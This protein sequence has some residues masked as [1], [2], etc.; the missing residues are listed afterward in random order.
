M[1]LLLGPAGSPLVTLVVPLV[2]GRLVLPQTPVPLRWS[3]SAPGTPGVTVLPLV[4]RVGDVTEV[5]VTAPAR[6]VLTEV[7]PGPE[8][9]T[10]VL[11]G[12]RPG[13]VI[14]GATG[15]PG[16]TFRGISYPYPRHFRSPHVSW[17][18][19]KRRTRCLTGNWE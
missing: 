10:P 5:T 17:G 15:D 19:R 4:G 7:R 3:A 14:L 1:G 9:S 6:T 12:S 2:V 13:L 8:R 16:V 18:Y 11:T